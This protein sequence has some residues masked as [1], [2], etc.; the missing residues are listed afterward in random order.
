M[1]PD[2]D[3]IFF[4]LT[5]YNRTYFSISFLFNFDQMSFNSE[6]TGHMF[7]RT[8]VYVSLGENIILDL[9]IYCTIFSAL[10]TDVFCILFL[11]M[12][13]YSLRTSLVSSWFSVENFKCSTKSEVFKIFSWRFTSKTLNDKKV[14]SSPK[15]CIF[16]NWTYIF[17]VQTYGFIFP[18]LLH[19]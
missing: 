1:K 17:N 5:S 16:L 7:L 4:I 8:C 9:K 10:F 13:K 19:K 11:Q 3:C 12:K 18:F 2:S 14:R 15:L 6:S